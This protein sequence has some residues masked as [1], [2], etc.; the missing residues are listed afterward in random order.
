[1]T[2]G[3]DAMQHDVRNRIAVY[4]SVAV[5]VV[6]IPLKLAQKLKH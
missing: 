1:M 5:F 4:S 2:Q 3:V 6:I